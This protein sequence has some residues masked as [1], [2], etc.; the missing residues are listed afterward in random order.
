MPNWAESMEQTFE[1]Y[2]VDTGTWKND[3]RLTSVLSSSITIDEESDTYGSASFDLSDTFGES[4]VRTYLVTVQNGVTE[5]FPLGTHLIQT[6]SSTFDGKMSSISVDAY[7]SLL[8]LKETPPPIGYYIAKG[9]NIMDIAYQLIREHC[10]APV[11]RLKL[12]DT[13]PSNFVSNSDDTWLTFLQDLVGICGYKLGVDEL[14]QIIFVPSTSPI[15]LTPIFEYTDDN[16]SILDANITL[17][18]DL[19]QVPNVVE[20]VYSTE[21][22]TYF[23]TAKNT[24]VNSPVSIPN[25]GREIITR[26]TDPNIVGD[27]DATDSQVQLYADNMLKQLSTVE[28]SM[29]Y[30]HGYCPVR[31]GDGI[32]MNYRRAD[33][34]NIKARVTSQ[35]INCQTG[36]TVSETA[37]YE[38]KLWR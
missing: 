12:A 28:Y 6:P 18:H 13:L 16:C 1:Y 33:L 19:Y 7:T 26:I 9:E 27:V 10:R 21:K 3:K 36:V 29:S 37:V 35:T 22:H 14:G 5:K 24:D 31:V 23:K 8:E 17:N 32:L 2:T 38:T 4:Y 15:S 20:V 11:I 25:R 30:T 34:N